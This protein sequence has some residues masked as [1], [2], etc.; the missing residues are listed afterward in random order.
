GENVVSRSFQI[1][2]PIIFASFNYRIGAL[3]FL[4]GQQVKD[5]GVSNLGLHDQRLALRWVRK[6]ISRF[7]GDPNRV[8]LWG[9][10]A[11]AISIRL[12]MVVNGGNTESLFRAA[13]MQ[14]GA[15]IPVGDIKNGQD[16]YNAL[17]TKLGCAK[18]K[19]SLSCIRKA[20]FESFYDAAN[21]VPG[22]LV[23]RVDGQILKETPFESIRDGRVARI[24]YVIGN[25]D[26]EGTIFAMQYLG[27]TT[28]D[29]MKAYLKSR[30]SRSEHLA[31]WNKS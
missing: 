16:V 28:E 1:G 15:P 4:G 14:S 2:Q 27:V 18:E 21:N 22:L 12:Q 17:A 26:D 13:F 6:Y 3:G 10:S 23:P 19:D 29:E 25:L 30:S 20:P 5:A 7:G 11:G 9:E 8:T 31:N 24:P